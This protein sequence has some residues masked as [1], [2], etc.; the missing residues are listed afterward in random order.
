MENWQKTAVIA[1]LVGVGATLLFARPGMARQQQSATVYTIIDNNGTIQ[2]IN[3]SNGNVD[4]SGTDATTVIN[5]TISNLP[6]DRWIA[7]STYKPLVVIKG[8][9]DVGTINLASMM[10]LQIA[11]GLKLADNTNGHL[12]TAQGDVEIFGGVLEGNKTNNV[13]SDIIHVDGW[14]LNYI[15]NIKMQNAASNGVHI[16]HTGGAG[17]GGGMGR[18]E[19]LIITDS[20]QNN[21]SVENT[22]DWHIT[23]IDSGRSGKAGIYFNN[24]GAHNVDEILVWES[25]EEG[26]LLNTCPESRF[27]AIRSDYNGREGIKLVNCNQTMLN[28]ISII[29]NS[30]NGTYYG[31][32]TTGGWNILI[33]NYLIYK[34]Y[35]NQ[36]NQIS[37]DNLGII[38]G[39][40][41]LQP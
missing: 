20:G 38:I 3:G 40:G 28:S 12:L 34:F 8:V 41:W 7:G 27:A 32:M 6:S 37:N 10:T 5:D 31:I 19:D 4:F 36:I 29:N 11:G 35:G 39:N 22:N 26:I 17:S 2:A 25:G 18:I 21:L 13:N 1:G 30:A 33:N 16:V 14:G 23:G 24:A 15:H 9:F